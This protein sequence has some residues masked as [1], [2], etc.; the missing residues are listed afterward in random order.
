[1]TFPEIARFPSGQVCT[2]TLAEMLRAQIAVPP[3]PAA[4]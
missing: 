4:A 2:M 1:M 3:G